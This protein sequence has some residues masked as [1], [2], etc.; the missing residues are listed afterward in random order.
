MSIKDELSKLTEDL[1]FVLNECSPADMKAL[2]NQLKSTTDMVKVDLAAKSKE[3]RLSPITNSS[4]VIKASEAAIG[5]LREL[6]NMTKGIAGH[7][8]GQLMSIEIA[9]PML[10]TA[11][12]ELI[13]A[14][15]D[16]ITDFVQIY[17]DEQQFLHRTQ[18]S[19][20][21]FSQRKELLRYKYELDA[22]KGMK[23]VDDDSMYY[24][25]EDVINA[26]DTK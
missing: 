23:T 14:T 8:Y 1:D 13:R 2:S 21:Q 20:L 25:Q 19:L 17:R 18:L 10:I 26:L 4:D 5:D 16:S 3:L 7:L 22:S 24:T 15:R 9:D 6:I 12:A 11:A